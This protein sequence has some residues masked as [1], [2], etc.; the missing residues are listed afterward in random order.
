MS[1]SSESQRNQQNNPKAKASL[2]ASLGA[3][4][5]AGSLAGMIALSGC[6]ADPKIQKNENL[7]KAP[8]MNPK[9]LR[10]DFK[11]PSTP[12]SLAQGKAL[13]QSNCATCHAPD[14]WQSPKVQTDLTYSTPIDYY[15]MLS[16]GESP[17]IAYPS[18]ERH[19]M[20]PQV[21]QDPKTGDTL[22]FRD[23]LTPDE[24]WAVLFYTRHLAGMDDLALNNKAGQPLK[25]QSD[26]FGGNCA[27]CH[28]NRGFA[29]GFLHS[30]KPSKHGPEGG[31]IHIGLFQPPPANFHDY[32][33]FYNRSDAQ[34][35]RYISQGIYPSAMPRWYGRVDKDKNFAYNDETIWK[36]VRFVRTFTYAV[37]LPDGEPTPPGILIDTHNDAWYHPQSSL[38]MGF[39]G[40]P[41]STAA[42]DMPGEAATHEEG[43]AAP[44][45]ETKKSGEHHS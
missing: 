43:A 10:D 31:K 1:A 4:L 36:L 24:R 11:F 8:D 16:R 9:L 25:V 19:Q 26:I 5:L 18:E 39:T 2:K 23:K 32:K 38:D 13:F 45:V 20:Q 27:V 7:F 41:A 29:D 30:G 37:D 33:R 40:N 6:A 17:E 42:T 3:A 21:H 28:G 15:L 44:Q 35:H 34:I 12:P 22:I 14:F